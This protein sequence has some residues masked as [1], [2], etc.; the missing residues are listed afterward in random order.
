MTIRVAPFSRSTTRL[1]R[2]GAP[3]W[4]RCRGFWGLARLSLLAVLLSML[5]GCL[6]DDPPPYVAPQQTAPRLDYTEASPGLD[7]LLIASH[8]DLIRFEMPF[9]S[10]DAGEQLYAV[11]WLDYDG[12]E[13]EQLNSGFFPPSTLADTS[14]RVLSLPWK[15]QERIVPGCHRFTL[16]VTHVGNTGTST[17]V[18]DKKDLAEAYWFANINVTAEN[19][20]SLVNCPQ[21]S[22]GGTP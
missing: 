11:L 21:A 16:R 19:A 10:E 4:G 9:T 17:K 8:P 1:S 7:Q 6:V 15:V 14:R 3:A 22:T 12:V 2:P 20:N 13:G 18:F 5:S